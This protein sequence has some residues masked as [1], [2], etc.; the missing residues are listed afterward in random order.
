MRVAVE[1]CL[2]CILLSKDDLNLW[3]NIKTNLTLI[4][5]MV[6]INRFYITFKQ[7]KN[8]YPKIRVCMGTQQ[9]FFLEPEEFENIAGKNSCR[10]HPF[11]PAFY[12]TCHLALRKAR[13]FNSAFR[14][15][16]DKPR[17]TRF[18]CYCITTQSSCNPLKL[19]GIILKLIMHASI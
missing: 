4:N 15:Y 18:I 9:L 2:I 11:P 7:I 3:G 19:H 17:I 10:R 14:D 5:L 1:V 13:V 8:R 6:Q 12:P 16:G